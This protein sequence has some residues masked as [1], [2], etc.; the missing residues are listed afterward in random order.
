MA[1]TNNASTYEDLSSLAG[2]QSEIAG[3]TWDQNKRDVYSGYADH[4][5]WLAENALNIEQAQADREFQREMSNTAYQRAVKDLEAAGFSPLALLSN[6]GSAS[7]PSGSA[8]SSSSARKSD[9]GEA[10]S[11]KIRSGFTDLAKT[12]LRILGLVAIKDLSGGFAAKK[13]GK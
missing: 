13:A 10:Y 5:R 1:M 6:P 4:T 9:F 2:R 3:N 8:A 12:A 7:T 11:K